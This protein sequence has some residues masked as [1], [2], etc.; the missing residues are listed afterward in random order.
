M[1]PTTGTGAQARPVP[2][3]PGLLAPPRP[4]AWR[5]RLA[6]RPGP[7]SSASGPGAGR[8]FFGL[9]RCIAAGLGGF[10]CRLGF[11]PFFASGGARGAPAPPAPAP[12]RSAF[13][14]SSTW[15]S[16]APGGAPAPGLRLAPSACTAPQAAAAVPRPAAGAGAGATRS[17][18][19]SRARSVAAAARNCFC[20]RAMAYD[21]AP[22]SLPAPRR[23]AARQQ[24]GYTLWR[25]AQPWLLAA[26]PQKSHHRRPIGAL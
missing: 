3:R 12:R 8:R 15:P 25:Q 7:A 2:A 18:A 22:M 4:P 20:T 5:G 16:S 19:A 21:P 6:G 11:G 13:P 14:T 24:R 17:A 10:L 1:L 23:Q 26:A 9:F